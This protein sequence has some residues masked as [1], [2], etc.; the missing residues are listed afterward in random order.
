MDFSLQYNYI[1]AVLIGLSIVCGH[2]PDCTHNK[3]TFI[4]E[5]PESCKD[6]VDWTLQYEQEEQIYDQNNKYFIEI[7]SSPTNNS[8]IFVGVLIAD[9]HGVL[10]VDDNQWQYVKIGNYNEF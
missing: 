2:S 10:P 4:K 1:N 7:F 5:A 9:K 3:R 8:E 6:Q